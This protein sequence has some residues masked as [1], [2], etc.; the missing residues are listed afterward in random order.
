MK[1][2][3]E[4]LEFDMPPINC[5]FYAKILILDLSKTVGL[6]ND[7]MKRELAQHTEN[8]LNKIPDI[9]SKTACNYLE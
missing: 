4:F 2:T 3:S 1:Q 6:H 5:E 9:M 8:M 7:P